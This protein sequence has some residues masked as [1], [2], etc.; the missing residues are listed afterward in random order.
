[1]SKNSV[2]VI[3]NHENRYLTKKHKWRSG[4][5]TSILFR[6]SERDVALN[7]LIEVNARDIHARLELVNCELED[8]HPVVEVL[9]EDSAEDLAEDQAEKDTAKALAQLTSRKKADLEL[10]QDNT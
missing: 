3:R 7:E 6:A 1:M 4:N 9:T 5:D 8:K 10:V 2:F